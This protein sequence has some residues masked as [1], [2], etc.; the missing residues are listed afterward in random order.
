MNT[1]FGIKPNSQANMYTRVRNWSQK[2]KLN[3]SSK[4]YVL[5][6]NYEKAIQSE[7]TLIYQVKINLSECVWFNVLYTSLSTQSI[8]LLPTSKNN[9]TQHYIHPKHKR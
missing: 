7:Y 6:L 3:V 1:N 5:L 8:A 9:E 4:Q 2:P